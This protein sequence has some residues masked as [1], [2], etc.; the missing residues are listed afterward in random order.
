MRQAGAVRFP[1]GLV[2]A[3]V[4]SIGLWAQQPA[5]SPDKRGQ[6]ASEAQPAAPHQPIAF[7]HKTHAALDLKCET[8]HSNPD[9]G[10][11]ITIADPAT[12]MT[13]HE[14]VATDSPEIK[15]LAE[16][17][18]AHKAVPWVR[19]YSVPDFVY[20]SHRTHLQADV[21]CQACH[22]QVEQMD[23]TARVTNV[24][25]MAG[26]VECHQQHN[27]NTGCSACHEGASAEL[28][29]MP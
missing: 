1:I 5:P 28:R 16:Y 13:C 7:S 27:A 8:C 14:S 3:G 9:P 15:K 22:G 18:Q 10:D 4:L 17:A 2:L 25:T 11:N 26:C 6:A 23:V 19:I 20:W 12:C 21:R 24:T 29:R